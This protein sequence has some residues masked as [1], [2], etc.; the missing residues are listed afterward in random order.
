MLGLSIVGFSL[1]AY[2]SFRDREG[3]FALLRSLGLSTGQLAALMWLE[4]AIVVVSGLALGTWMGGR[5]GAAIVPFIGSDETGRQPL[6]PF[7]LEID[8][9]TL[10]GTYSAMIAVFA[11]VIVGV[12]I[13]VRRI[14]LQQVL[15]TG[16]L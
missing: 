11:I 4:Q 10:L 12:I 1:H 13:V 15:K 5:L 14:T 3:Q 16:D 9:P 8:W 2:L 7:V 6:P